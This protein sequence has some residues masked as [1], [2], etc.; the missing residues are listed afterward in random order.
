MKTLSLLS[1]PVSSKRNIN[2]TYVCHLNHI[3]KKWN[4]KQTKFNNLFSPCAPDIINTSLIYIYISLNMSL[5]HICMC[6]CLIY[7]TSQV[8][9]GV[10][11]PAANAGDKRHEFDPWVG[12]IWR[13]AWQPTPVFFPGESHGQRSGLVGYSPWGRKESDTSQA[14]WHKVH[15]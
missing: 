5:I 6:M 3:A 7:R 12:K 4:R 14:T 8:A 9:L 13:R 11:N 15:C 1:K 2:M 10:K